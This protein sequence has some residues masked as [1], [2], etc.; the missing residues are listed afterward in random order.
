IKLKTAIGTFNAYYDQF[1]FPFLLTN[2]ATLTKGKDFL[3]EYNSKSISNTYIIVK[4]KNENK[5]TN[6][7]GADEFKRSQKITVNRL[8]QN[9]RVELQKRIGT[10]TR[11]RLRAEVVDVYYSKINPHENGYLIFGDFKIEPIRNLKINSRFIF[12]QTDSY[13]SRVY[14]FEND[15]SGVLYNPGL[16]GRGLRWYIV[17]Q[18]RVLNFL[19]ISFKYS[20]TIRDDVKKIGSGDSEING[21]LDNRFSI[22]IELKL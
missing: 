17:T 12:Y 21:N 19:D 2:N 3:I 20:E 13:D 18:Y 9:L 16:Y 6:E 14:E 4:Y 11:L 10:N 15:L 22:Q 8:Q 1:H 7:Y 5:E